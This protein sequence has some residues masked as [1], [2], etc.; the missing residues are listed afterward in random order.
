MPVANGQP[1]PISFGGQLLEWGAQYLLSQQQ[2]PQQL[3]QQLLQQF[4]LQLTDQGGGRTT[5]TVRLPPVPQDVL[6]TLKAVDDA[7]GKM[8]DKVNSI[9]DLNKDYYK[10]YKKLTVTSPSSSGPGTS[11]GPL[12][13]SKGPGG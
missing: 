1:A 3:L 6:D 4:G 8:V 2:S 7:Q 5:N 12:G 10:N 11:G 9:A 13:S